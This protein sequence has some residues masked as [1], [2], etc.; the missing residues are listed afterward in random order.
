[1][2]PGGQELGTGINPS[3][4]QQTS[5]RGLGD[6]HIH[7]KP[8]VVGWV[9][10]VQ[11]CHGCPEWELQGRQRQ[12]VLG[13][14]QAT[15]VWLCQATSR[16]GGPQLLKY[17]WGSGLVS[18]AGQSLQCE[19]S[20]KRTSVMPLGVMVASHLS[21][22]SPSSTKGYNALGQQITPASQDRWDHSQVELP[23]KKTQPK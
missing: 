13:A 20:G 11:N 14:G 4:N 22:P 12:W 9:R 19:N 15:A 17:L 6:P 7:M 3:E 18:E 10:R 5:S 1:M 8:I 23:P 2:A 21:L 16:R